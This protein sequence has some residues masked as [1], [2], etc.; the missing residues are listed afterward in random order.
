MDFTK[1]KSIDDIEV[2]DKRILM[3]VDFN[4]PLEN[5][6]VKSDLR[7]RA[8]LPTIQALLNRG[9]RVILVSHLGRPKGKVD[10]QFS[11]RPVLAALTKLVTAPVHFCESIDSL[12]SQSE[13]LKSGEIL[14]LE[15]IR[16]YEGEEKND[17]DLSAKLAK[18]GDVYVNDAFGTAHRA[19]ASTAGITQKLRPAVSGYLMKKE[20]DF[21]GKV[22]SNP[23]APFIAVIGGAKISG[24]IDVIE[25]LAPKVDQLLIG[26][27]MAY[28]FYKAKGYNIGKSLVEDDRVEMAK[29]LLSRF[30]DKLLLPTDCFVSTEFDFEARKIGQLK[31]VAANSMS[32]NDIGLDIGPATIESYKQ[33]LAKARTVLWNGPM[34]VFE[35]D[36]TAKGTFAIANTLAE[37][38][39]HGAITVIGGGDSAAAIE[40]A[41]L[42]NRVSHVS[43]GGGASLELLEGKELPGVIA[44]DSK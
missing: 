38:T 29:E 28:T 4:V 30:A 36:A 25:N 42:A 20:L 1:I 26:G 22:I 11:L 27:A 5:G 15:N 23:E 34:G 19:H 33:I 31:S 41:N 3:R 32:D 18:A 2:K 21:L 6:Q 10:P 44:L 13:S 40:K 24:K 16:F 43:T 39:D 12:Q 35:I 14:L 17:A 9:G 7:I 37:I 8:A